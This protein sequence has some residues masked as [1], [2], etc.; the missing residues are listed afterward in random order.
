[1]NH[2]KKPLKG[3]M[4][5]IINLDWDKT[6]MVPYH[7]EHDQCRFFVPV[8]ISVQDLDFRGWPVSLLGMRL[9]YATF[10]Q[11]SSSCTPINRWTQ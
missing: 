7:V 3:K 6:S 4:V 9:T 2:I 10:P 11:E 5:H 8:M 1:M